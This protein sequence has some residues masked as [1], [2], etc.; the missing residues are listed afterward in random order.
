MS[1]V[2]EYRGLMRVARE[3]EQEAQTTQN[4]I[5]RGR[6]LERAAEYRREAMR[7]GREADWECAEIDDDE[8]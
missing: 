4:V 2:G 6:L 3:L 5:L 1:F 8:E 7:I